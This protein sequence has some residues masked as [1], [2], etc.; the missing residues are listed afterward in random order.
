MAELVPGLT[1]ECRW[2][3]TD[4]LTAA[5]IGS[6]L[7]AV[8][9]TPMLVGLMESAAVD[10]LKNALEPGLTSVGTRI[11]VKHLAATPVGLQV[12][13]TATLKEMDGRRLIFEIEAWDDVEKIG[14]A[15]HERFIVNL[16]RF[17]ARAAQKHT[18]QDRP[19]GA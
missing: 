7:V 9:S 5:Q 17:E 13:A 2:T 6:G 3:V 1:G 12:R 4:D 16:Q 15:T 10:A 19:P 8:F 14:E 18:S 11:D